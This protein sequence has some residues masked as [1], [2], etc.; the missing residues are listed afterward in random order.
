[1]A[2]VRLGDAPY[3]ERAQEAVRIQRA[4]AEHLGEAPGGDAPV[5]LEL[6]EPVLRMHE[7]ERELRVGFRLRK[8]VRHA[9][10]VAQHLD[11]SA[12]ARH[13]DLAAGRRQRQ[14]QIQ[15]GAARG[16]RER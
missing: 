4:R 2:H 9:V 16:R 7:A 1:M 14:A 10:L 13:R 11:R 8:Y 5:H 12:E 6:P 15:I 3:A